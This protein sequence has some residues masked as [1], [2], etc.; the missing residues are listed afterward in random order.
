[1]QT[2]VKGTSPS[3]RNEKVCLRSER[4]QRCHQR[5]IL[6]FMCKKVLKQSSS[7]AKQLTA[8]I[9]RPLPAPVL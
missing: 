7:C 4:R 1:M 6:F 2:M 5:L 9:R 8:K 3:R